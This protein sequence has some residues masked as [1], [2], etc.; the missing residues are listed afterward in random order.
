MKS[1]NDSTSFDSSDEEGL[2]D[3]HAQEGTTRHGSAMPQPVH[4]PSGF[5]A[6][7]LM[8]LGI[9]CVAGGLALSLGPKVSWKVAQIATGFKHLGVE[10][11]VL[12]MGGL[13]LVAIGMLRRGQIALRTPSPE[14]AEDRAMIE[15]LTKDSIRHSEELAHME[16][17]LAH[18]EA[19]V[20]A[21]RRVLEERMQ[22][23]SQA[24]LSAVTAPKDSGSSEEAIFRLAASLDQVGMRIEQR[25]KTQYTALQDHLEDVGA[26]ILSARNQV[27]GL[28]RSGIDHAAA[29][30]NEVQTQVETALEQTGYWSTERQNQGQTPSLGVLDSLGDDNQN[31]EELESI[32]AALP[33]DPEEA[34]EHGAATPPMF[35]QDEIDTKTRLVQLS[36]LLTDPKLRK[37]LEGIRNQNL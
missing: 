33:E 7:F 28:Q 25:L 4:A 3:S 23:N 34:R 2:D 26:A 29:L 32:D 10:G 19:E 11:G 18:V 13:I 24:I 36:T 21:S 5:D 22:A 27:Q 14:Q 31:D 20:T 12:A 30:R 37:A 8:L 1:H 6:A 16:S 15:Q 17:G 9:G 35:D